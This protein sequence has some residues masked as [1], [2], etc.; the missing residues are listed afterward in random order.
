MQLFNGFEA[1]LK[2]S[3]PDEV[4]VAAVL[5]NALRVYGHEIGE[6][7]RAVR[8]RG[9]VH[10][11]HLAENRPY[12]RAAHLRCREEIANRYAPRVSP[13]CLHFSALR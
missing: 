4:R 6:L 9:G 10:L 13:S 12:Q 8:G 2:T 1:N 11:E 5:Q 7:S 3:R